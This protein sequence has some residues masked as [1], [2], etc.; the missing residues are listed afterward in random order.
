M[1]KNRNLLRIPVSGTAKRKKIAYAAVILLLSAGLPGLNACNSAADNH[2]LDAFDAQAHRGGRGLMPENTIASEKNAIDFNSTLEMDLQMSKDS[3]VVVSHDA[4][5]NADFCLTP[6]GKTMDKKDGRSRLL[7]NMTYDSIRKYDVGLKPHPGF[8]RQKKVAAVR[9]LLSV[10]ID[11][12]EAY[13]K[14]K[15]HTNHYN[16]EL[17]TSPKEDGVHY[18]DLGTYV[19]RALHIV[20]DKG[21][22]DRT[23]IQSFDVRALRMVHDSF[24]DIE[25]SYLVG[26]NDTNT[27]QGYISK[28]GFTPA[29]FSPD[30]H[31]VTPDMVAGFH[32]QGVKVIPWT[33][34]TLEEIQNLKDMGVD[35]IITD[36]PDLYSQLKK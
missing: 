21:I 4:Y 10:L 23:M 20:N 2:P 31:I 24:P 35:G 11:S 9:P 27:V 18:P 5:F 8:P 34:N 13:A 29:V 25:T 16:I 7:F 26:K 15:G 1:K 30:Y 17:K 33:P 28:L 6:E 36:Y 3:Q 32:K 12:V 14:T 19:S 22:A